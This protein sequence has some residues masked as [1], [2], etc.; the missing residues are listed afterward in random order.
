MVGKRS[1]LGP[2]VATLLLPLPLAYADPPC[3]APRDCDGDGVRDNRDNCHEDANA[4][5][6]D[7]DGDGLGDACDDYLCPGP[8]EVLGDE[9][10]DGV[11]NDCDGVV[12]GD[13]GECHAEGE[14][15]LSVTGA[16]ITL[17]NEDP[18]PGEEV[19]VRAAIHNNGPGG[20][21]DLSVRFLLGGNPVGNATVAALGAGDVARVAQ[22]VVLP[23]GWQVIQ[24]QVDPDDDVPETDEGNNIATRLL[25]VGPPPPARARIVVRASAN[26]VCPTGQAH[27]TGDARY[28]IDDA[29]E[30]L[31]FPVQ[32]GAITATLADAGIELVGRHTDGNGQFHLRF[33]SPEAPAIY[34]LVVEVSDSGVTG[35]FEGV[36]VVQNADKCQ[37]DGGGGANPSGMGGG[38]GGGG[39][40]GGD[41]AGDGPGGGGGG[42]AGGGGGGGA[43][44]GGGVQGGGSGVVRAENVFLHSEHIGF[45]PTDAPDLG[46]EITISARIH[47][48][49]VEAR[50]FIP[51]EF[52]THHGDGG[53]LLETV[54]GRSV[55]SFPDG[56]ASSPVLVQTPWTNADTGPH[57]VQIVTLP[58]FLQPEQDDAA[59]RLIGVSGPLI[60]R[61]RARLRPDPDPYPSPDLC[62]A[63]PV[64]GV[65]ELPAPYHVRDLDFA[66]L[67][68]FVVN[69]LERK[70]LDGDGSLFLRALAATVV[71]GDE[72]RNGVPDA[73]FE[74]HADALSAVVPP[75][76]ELTVQFV[77]FLLDSTAV[78]ATALLQVDG[79]DRDDD[80]V[81]DTCDNCPDVQNPDQADA[82][83]DGV[84]DACAV[85]PGGGVEDPEGD[86]GV[87]GADPARGDGAPGP[88][89]PDAAAGAPLH[90]G[91]AGDRTTDGPG[92]GDAGNP[93]PGC[94]CRL[95]PAAAGQG[96]GRTLPLVLFLAML[97]RRRRPN[98]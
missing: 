37:A 23:A 48:S 88:R 65:I 54:V 67:G 43:G 61:A 73:S 2:L 72:D 39:G 95:S 24:V 97:R 68:L 58:S 91:P 86:A 78:E 11:D 20:V 77:G 57:I 51:V 14:T 55:V 82:E 27:L 74:L 87:N 13:D 81:G 38:E 15:D 46:Q 5:Q 26:V 36:L 6:A 44:G 16:D 1:F 41:G 4:D 40:G 29:G 63:A 66:G 34:E 22:R 53:R 59:T 31:T 56:E 71:I 35:E 9:V 80:G 64:I 7:A 19:V 18:A 32:G 69:P 17:S 21:V 98:R 10:C 85:A 92:A 94:S 79:A 47:Y 90:D 70:D 84:G 45:D 89:G 33:L 30:I 75:A 42:G 3:Q 50:M 76:G 28:E 52:V 8:G 83:A 96:A 12:D 93:A 25:R 49:G 62:P 60:F